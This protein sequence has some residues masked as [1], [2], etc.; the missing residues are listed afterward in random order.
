M[1]PGVEIVCSRGGDVGRVADHRERALVAGADVADDRGAGV[2][3]DAEPWPVVVPLAALGRVADR[4]RRA[5]GAEAW[6][7]W[8][9]SALNTASTASPA[10]RSI[11]PPSRS[12]TAGTTAAPVGV[13]H[14]DDLARRAVP[15]AKVVNPARSAN[16]TETS[17]SRPPSSANVRV[18]RRSARPAE[19]RRIGEAAHP[20]AR[21]R[22]RSRAARRSRSPEKPSSRSLRGRRVERTLPL[23]ARELLQ[24][25]R[26][27]GIEPLERPLQ[28]EPAERPGERAL[29]PVLV[30][31][32]EQDRANA[33]AIST[34]HSH[35][36]SVPRA[37]ERHGDQ[38]LG[39]QHE[40]RRHR[41]RQGPAPASGRCARYRHAAKAYAATPNGS[42]TSSHGARS[43]SRTRSSGGTPRSEATAQASSTASSRPAS[44]AASDAAHASRRSS[45]SIADGGGERGG[46]EQPDR[47]GQRE[48][49]VGARQHHARGRQRVQARK[50]GARE[51][52]HRDQEQPRVVALPRGLADQ[53]AEHDVQDRD[54]QHQPEVGRVVLPVQV[55]RGDAQQQRQAGE[56]EGERDG[57]QRERGAVTASI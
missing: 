12:T 43:A 6:S 9:P 26:L 54:P 22:V 46:D 20:R 5:H 49:A 50:P 15:S 38:R 48:P 51:Q 18:P 32:R 16:S 14:L 1:W 23:G 10:N 3:A 45:S 57:D 28:V 40:R 19:G 8:S 7:G 25:R 21:A 4:H 27:A 47:G 52:H 39:Q 30:S 37:A 41:Q 36:E 44:A 35:H 13:Q 42:R 24:R 2:H 34:C 31:R 33:T 53:Q 29:L 17:A 56:R 11:S 55:D